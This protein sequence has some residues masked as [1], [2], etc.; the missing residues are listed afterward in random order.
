MV[1]SMMPV[2]LLIMLLVG[3]CR[4]HINA[5]CVST[6][7]NDAGKATFHV[8]TYH[9]TTTGIGSICL[10]FNGGAETC[11]TYSVSSAARTIPAASPAPRLPLCAL[12]GNEAHRS[13]RRHRQNCYSIPSTTR[14]SATAL[15]AQILARSGIGASSAVTCYK[16][17]GGSGVAVANSGQAIVSPSGL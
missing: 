16:Q 3:S 2:H 1:G 6:D 10:S 8:G 12:L 7:P 11:Y 4:G 17:T 14:A 13:N 15:D 5:M 9:T